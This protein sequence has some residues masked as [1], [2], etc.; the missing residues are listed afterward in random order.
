MKA[1]CTKT[2]GPPQSVE[3][4]RTNKRQDNENSHL[5]LAVDDAL[6]FD[7]GVQQA[8]VLLLVI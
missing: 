6:I 5:V 7:V 1:V 3:I 2:E 4:A 8:N